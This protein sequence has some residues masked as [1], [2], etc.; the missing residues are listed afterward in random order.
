MSTVRFAHVCDSC[1]KRSAEYGIFLRCFYCGDHTCRVCAK[2][3][4]PD[5]PGYAV[6]KPCGAQDEAINRFWR[7]V[8]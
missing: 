1:G 5:P 2:E 3:Y 4:D 8:A 6:C 7:E